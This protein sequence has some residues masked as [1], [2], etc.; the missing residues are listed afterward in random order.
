VLSES[1]MSPTASARA[2]FKFYVG[3]SVEAQFTG[4]TRYY[5]GVVRKVLACLLACVFSKGEDWPGLLAIASLI[6]GNVTL[7]IY[8]IRFLK[9]YKPRYPSS[10]S[11]CFFVCLLEEKSFSSMHFVKINCVLCYA[12][13]S[14]GM[15]LTAFNTKMA[16]KSGLCPKR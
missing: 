11:V 16:T 7:P 13:R 5:P 3:Q 9:I 10:S 12:V 1:P 4:T 6:L 14:T 15:A 8:L 2:G